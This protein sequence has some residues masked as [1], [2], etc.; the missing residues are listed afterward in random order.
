[1]NLLVPM[2]RRV[3]WTALENSEVRSYSNES[4]VHEAA[5]T[6]SINQLWNPS[7]AA[8]DAEALRSKNV[9]KAAQESIKDL[10]DQAAGKPGETGGGNRDGETGGNRDRE[11]GGNRD[12]RVC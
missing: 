3:D 8:A 9:S 5:G 1:M 6:R 4:Y 12:R 7:W 2:N 10:K 11:T